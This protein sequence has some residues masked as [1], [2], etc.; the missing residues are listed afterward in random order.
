MDRYLVPVMP[1]MVWTLGSAVIIL[2][3]AIVRFVRIGLGRVNL[4]PHPAL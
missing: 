2:F 1:V 3:Q 4:Q